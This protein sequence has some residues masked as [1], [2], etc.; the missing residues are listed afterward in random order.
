MT[1]YDKERDTIQMM[2]KEIVKMENGKDSS[3]R[4]KYLDLMVTSYVGEK[5]EDIPGQP[6]RKTRRLR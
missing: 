4:G 3:M 5:A 6:E 1:G 2:A